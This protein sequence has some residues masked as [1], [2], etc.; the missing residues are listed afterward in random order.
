M[1]M[2][3]NQRVYYIYIYGVYLQSRIELAA[4]ERQWQT[5]EDPPWPD[6]YKCV[7][8]ESPNNEKGT[9]A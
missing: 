4:R 6:T 3:N 8:E 2:L 9:P 5:V 7:L 1:A